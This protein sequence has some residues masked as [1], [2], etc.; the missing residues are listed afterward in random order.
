M[1]EININLLNSE[2][3]QSSGEDNHLQLHKGQQNRC[4]LWEQDF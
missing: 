2:A 1:Q 3:N 4:Y